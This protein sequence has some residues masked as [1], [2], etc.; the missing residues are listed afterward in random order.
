[1][2]RTMT[3]KD[4]DKFIQLCHEFYHSN[5]VLNPVP[6]S[7]FEKTFSVVLEK[8]PFVDGYLFEFD[9]KTVGYALFSFTYSNEVAGKVLW[10]EEVYI[11]P[12]YQG[13]GL[14]KE[15]FQFIEQEYASKVKRVRLEVSPDNT[16]VIQLYERLGFKTLDYI[17]MAKQY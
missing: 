12:E 9:N 5:A 13:N 3:E 4:R 16:R 7:Y 15:L 10:V 2:L 17:Q 6:D 8:S 14:A 1:M 11:Q